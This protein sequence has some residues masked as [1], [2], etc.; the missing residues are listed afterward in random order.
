MPHVR[1]ND[2]AWEELRKF[3]EFKASRGDTNTFRYLPPPKFG[4]SDSVRVSVRPV[5]AD[6]DSGPA[7]LLDLYERAESGK[8][9]AGAEAISAT[10]AAS[11]A[12]LGAV[13]TYCRYD[14]GNDEGFAY[15]DHCV[16]KDESV[17][18][19]ECV[20][21][22]LMAANTA[23]FANARQVLGKFA[24]GFPEIGPLAYVRWLLDMGVAHEWAVQLL[25]RGY[26]TGEYSMYGAFW[27]D[28][29]TGLVT[30]DPDAQPRGK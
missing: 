3:D 22:D 28:L 16:F 8:R 15:F 7:S 27:V 26:G 11:L 23:L 12:A 9:G 25:G 24:H 19:A 6:A 21:R 13:R 14:G 20:A 18:N 17:R 30:D 29:E 5:T 2:D 1:T 4:L 10:L